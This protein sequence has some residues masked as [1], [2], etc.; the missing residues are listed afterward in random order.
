MTTNK[1]AGFSGHYHALCLQLS[2]YLNNNEAS[3]EILNAAR[4]DGNCFAKK[5]VSKTALLYFLQEKGLLNTPQGEAVG[6][7]NY[8]N[9]CLRPLFNRYS[10]LSDGL[11][12]MYIPNKF[13]R[14]RGTGI[15]DVF[16]QYNFILHEAETTPPDMAV[17]P[18]MLGDAFENTFNPGERK[19]K[20]TFYTPKEIVRY[21]CSESLQYY[22]GEEYPAKIQA[23]ADH[24]DE[25]LYKIKICDPAVGAGAFTVGML[26]EL[27]NAQMQ[28]LPHVSKPYLERKLQRLSLSEWDIGNNPNKYIHAI[29]LHAIQQSLYGVDID[30]SAIDIAKMRLWLSLAAYI[31]D[32]SLDPMPS[33]RCNIIQ[34]NA[35]TGLPQQW[36]NTFDIVIGN[37]PYGVYQGTKKDEL[38]TIRKMPRFATAKGQKLNAYE[39]FL[40]IAPELCRQD[41][42]IISM[43]FQNSFLGDTS[44]R[45]LRQFYLQNKRVI[46]IDSFP[47]RDD[48]SKRVFRHAKMSVC[49]LFAKNSRTT[50]PSFD[51]NIWRD[52]Y[53]NEG[54]TA[55]IDVKSIMKLDPLYYSI[56]SVSEAE[57]RVLQQLSG[58]KKLSGI[59]RCYEGEVNLTFRKE[60]LNTQQLPGYF[61][62][63]KGAAI[64]RW[65]LV[66][67]M[68]QGTVEYV[69]PAYV[70]DRSR[71][72]KSKHHQ[73]QRLV[74]QGITGV[75]ESFRLKF[76]LLG[77]Q[78]FCG[79]S[80]NYVVFRNPALT[81]PYLAILNSSLLNWYFKKYST[82]SNVNGYEVDN[83]PVTAISDNETILLTTIACYLEWIA[84]KN[85]HRTLYT[86]FNSLNN[87]IVYELYFKAAFKQAN[88]SIVEATG[89]LDPINQYMS[90]EEK[91]SIIQSA[92]QRL[93][94]DHH[95]LH[96]KLDVMNMIEPVRIIMQ[97]LH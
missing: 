6:N 86:F 38:E 70:Q 54:T 19:H 52:R 12:D 16:D 89:I 68:S 71:S 72:V 21:M 2:N 73:Q 88:V 41:S 94:N 24:F 17:H 15:L 47:E 3:G 43:I 81:I 4:L 1:A 30:A 97:S 20:G 49:I 75:D 58:F 31:D 93:N 64:H 35:L 51:L 23:N 32:V 11:P 74:M 82:N 76:A 56:P 39:L 63:I 57:Y 48:R 85:D 59:A 14:N 42:G 95:P 5:L 33:L 55:R 67:K 26:Q 66:K 36:E 22:L 96:H 7:I 61:P 91:L 53:F 29:M 10:M 60:Y 46:K 45:L 65:H 9:D 28:L 80:V 25:R 50:D 87:A 77:N 34:G 18:G 44:S 27:V 37:P 62:M 8:Y 69:S 79:N 83:L 92:Y 84:D 40:C 78:V 13:F 90:D